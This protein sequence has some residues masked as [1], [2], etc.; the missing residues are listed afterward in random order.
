MQWVIDNWIWIALG[1]GVIAL[2]MFGHGGHGGHGKSR[3]ESTR[4]DPSAE[5]AAPSTAAAGKSIRVTGDT[6]M[7]EKNP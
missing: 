7:D 4:P 1:V 2:H 3:K 6:G 5:P